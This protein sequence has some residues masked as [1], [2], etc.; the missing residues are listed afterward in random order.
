MRF[1]IPTLQKNTHGNEVKNLHY[2]LFFLIQKINDPALN[3]FFNDSGFRNHYKTEV[4]N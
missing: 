4:S 1:I 3:N 2:I